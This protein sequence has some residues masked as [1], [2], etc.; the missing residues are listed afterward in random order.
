MPGIIEVS[1][2][3]AIGDAI[4]D[5]LLLIEAGTPADFENQVRYVPMR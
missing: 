5:L 4:A 2:Q 3:S 1:Q